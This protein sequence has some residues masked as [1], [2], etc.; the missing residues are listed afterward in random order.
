[1]IDD[2]GRV[3]HDIRLEHPVERVWRAIAE[4]DELAQWLMT[5][6]FEPRVGHRF[7]FD[8][9]PP[10]GFIDAEVLVLD[11]PRRIAWRWMLDGV[12]T[13]VTITLEPDGDGTRLHLEHT[14]LPDDLRSRF[15]P[16]WTEKFAALTAALER[17][18]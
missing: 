8:A 2:D 1:M 13:T 16:G 6:D 14:D 4:R 5:N 9:G 3:I 15:E 7:R 12:A 10:R 17:V 18:P 11:P